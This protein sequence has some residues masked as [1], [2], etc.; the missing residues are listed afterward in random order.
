M[1]NALDAGRVDDAAA[2]FDVAA[3]GAAAAGA[4]RLVLSVEPATGR[5]ADLADRLGL[6]LDREVLQLRGRLPADDRPTITVRPF[7]PGADDEAWL[8]TNNRAFTWHPDQGGWTLADL[9]RTMAEPWFDPAGF[10][11]HERDGRLA[12]FCWTKVHRDSAPPLG[13]IFVIAV[14]PDFHGEGLGRE[15]TLAGLDWLADRGLTGSM[16]YV[17]ADNAP[18]GSLYRDLGFTPHHAKRWWVRNLSVA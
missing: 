11:V 7:V 2:V 12:G 16:L 4:D 5:H 17:E 15:L 18:A 14:D 1:A 3:R 9:A 10:L 8:E 6:R 13:E